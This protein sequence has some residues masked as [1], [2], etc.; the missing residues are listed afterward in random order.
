MIPL[1][2]VEKLKGHAFPG[3]SFT[4]QPYEN[5]LLK[6]IFGTGPLP[7]GAAHPMY[8]YFVAMA[9]AGISIGGIFELA[10][11]SDD[12][13]VMFGEASIEQLRPLREGET[14]AVSGGVTD[15][16]RKS[17]GR[18]GTFDIVT[19]RLELREPD[20]TLAGVSTNSFVFPRPE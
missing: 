12:S 18:I 14:Y 5:W 6:D 9:G 10:G 19:F 3:G 16:A 4:I 15:V 7:G 2:E 11:A 8:V 20:G 17:G 13:G 1:E